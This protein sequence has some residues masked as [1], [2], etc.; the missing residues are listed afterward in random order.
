MDLTL[1]TAISMTLDNGIS[2]FKN[3]SA[4]TDSY[5]MM[6][7]RIYGQAILTLLLAHEVREFFQL[8]AGDDP[9]GGIF[10]VTTLTRQPNFWVHLNTFSDLTLLRLYAF[11][12]KFG[13]SGATGTTGGGTT[14]SGS[15]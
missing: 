10:F 2:F 4:V 14:G 13:D 12:N 1:G 7:A 5:W 3:F 15:S 9:T 8:D 6:A 11:F